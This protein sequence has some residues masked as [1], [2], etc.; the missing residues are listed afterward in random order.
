MARENAPH[1]EP[2][3]LCGIQAGWTEKDHV[4]AATTGELEAL[5]MQRSLTD[6]QLLAAADAASDFRILPDDGIHVQIAIT[7]IP[8]EEGQK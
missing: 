5:L 3:A 1:R 8:D 6:R 7:L 4:M 2:S